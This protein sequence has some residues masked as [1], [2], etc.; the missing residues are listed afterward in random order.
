MFEVANHDKS[1]KTMTFLRGGFQGGRGWQLNGTT[2][3]IDPTPPFFIENVF[4][5]LD[6]PTEWFFNETA[7]KLYLY[8]NSTSSTPPPS[9]VK[10]VVPVLKRLITIIGTKE[11]PAAA[12]TIRGLGFRDAAHTY[13]DPWGVPSGGDWALHRGGAVFL[14][15]TEGVTVQGNLFK[16]VDGNALF[17]SGYN[18][19]AVLDDNEFN[20]VGD[21]AMAAWGYTDEHD[22]TGGEQPRGRNSSS[23]KARA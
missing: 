17:L 11:K 22:G 5:E 19:G 9:E 16:R 8:W 10:F 18:R 12:I 20:F 14:E 4:E 1:A 7:R 2:G 3:A 21:T 23:S 15:G 13:M 6:A